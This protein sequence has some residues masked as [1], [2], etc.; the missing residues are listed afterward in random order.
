MNKFMLKSER[1]FANILLVIIILALVLTNAVTFYYLYQKSQ[2]QQNK[3]NLTNQNVAL[4]STNINADTNINAN[5]DQPNVDLKTEEILVD[6]SEWP[7]PVNFYQLYDDDQAYQEMTERLKTA[8]RFIG[9]TSVSNFINDFKVYKVGKIKAG[10]YSGNNLYIIANYPD[11]P[12]LRPNSY[13]VI[14]NGNELISLAK[15]SDKVEAEFSKIFTTNDQIVI[16]N[17]ETPAE[18]KI[19]DSNYRLLKKPIEPFALLTSYDNPKKLFKLDNDNYLYQDISKSNC[20]IVKANDGTVREYYF[21]LPFILG[22]DS[23]IENNYA[24]F[25][26][27]NMDITWLDGSKNSAKYFSKKITGC[28][29]IGCYNYAWYLSSVNQLEKAGA[30]TDGSSVY[31]LKD[32]NQKTKA[33]DAKSILQ[34]MYDSYYPGWDSVTKT[35]KTKVGYDEF[36]TDKPLIYWQDSFGNFIEFRKE[37]YVPAVECGKPVIYLYPKT[38]TDVSVWVN[39]TGGFTITEPNYNNGWIVKAS[40]NGQLYNYN[41]KKVYPYLF[42]EGH[43][44]NYAQPKQGFIVAKPEVKKFLEEKLAQLGLIKKESDEFISFWLPKMQKSDYYFVTFVPQSE[45]DK[46]APLT[47]QPK[48]DTIIRVF[49]DYTELSAPISVTPQKITTPQRIGFTVV[50]W[51]GALHR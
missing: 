14:K 45:F 21:D 51:G 5:Q 10:S 15:Y 50:E 36:L 29:G 20:F 30:T 3:T 19:P 24:G 18:I 38:T 49:M 43:G 12:A 25:V 26:A 17:L 28:G 46:L 11:G 16:S 23:D 34:E 9:S 2:A 40:P 41:D 8:E 27:Q 37:Q 42:W 39:P 6:W 32:Q 13:R 22:T 44:L 4:D 33:S 35:V 7:A 48:P 47:V 31:V 1:G